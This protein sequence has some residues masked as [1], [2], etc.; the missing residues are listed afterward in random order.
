MSL[1]MPGGAVDSTTYGGAG[2]FRV[3]IMMEKRKSRAEI[4]IG[5]EN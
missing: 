2:V 3:S 4:N 5:V 1:T